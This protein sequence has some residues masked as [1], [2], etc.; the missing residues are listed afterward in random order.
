MK[1]TKLG[2]LMVIA[3]FWMA[4]IAWSQE[5]GQ[6]TVE[7]AQEAIQETVHETV[8]EAVEQIQETVQEAIE[9]TQATPMVEE[10]ES[11]SI[12]GE[13]VP[14][15]KGTEDSD[16][17]TI[18]VYQ[19]P[20]QTATGAAVV[21]CPGGGYGHLA[22]DHEGKQVGEWLNR[23]GIT[24]FVLKY[25][26]APKYQHPIPMRDAERAIKYV[27]LNAEKFNIHP[28]KIGILGFSAGGHLASTVGTQFDFGVTGSKDPVAQVS[29]KP[30]FMVL[31]YPV[32]TLENDYGHA[33]SRKNLLGDNPTPELIQ[34]LS[35]HKQVVP[36]IPPTFLV[37]T[38]DDTVVPVE[39]SMLFFSAMRHVGVPGALHI[40][41]KGKHGFGL[42]ANDPVLSKWPELCI[43]WIRENGFLN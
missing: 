15:A 39:N 24:G 10:H 12:W 4:P 40:F 19:A 32:I 25:R 38:L 34:Q 2:I 5:D 17:P 21:I 20:A 27:R 22:L 29:S 43:D 16:I 41:Q 14:G 33:G 42:G 13:K 37:H 36:Y 3:A 23:N 26:I 9:S 1:S 11:I 8:Q 30:N 18:T 31:V 7:Q 35:N 28:E 6:E